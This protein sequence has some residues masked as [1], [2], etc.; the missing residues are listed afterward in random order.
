MV[1]FAYQQLVKLL[2]EKYENTKFPIIDAIAQDDNKEDEEYEQ[3]SQKYKGAKRSWCVFPDN[4]D[5]KSLH[6]TRGLV[7]LGN[8]CFFNSVL[9][10]FA[11]THQLVSHY[12]P[13]DEIFNS[14]A[15]EKKYALWTGPLSL[16][17]KLFY[18]EMYSTYNQN[19]L[20]QQNSKLLRFNLET[21]TP[22]KLFK[23]IIKIVPHFRGFGQQDSQELLRFLQNFVRE[24][25]TLKLEKSGIKVDSNSSTSN[26]IIDHVFN[27]RMTSTV[28]CEHC[29]N[30]SQIYASELDVSVPIP[31]VNEIESD[32]LE[33]M[34]NREHALHSKYSQLL[35]PELIYSK[36]LEYQKQLQKK[37]SVSLHH[38]LWKHMSSDFLDKSGD[39]GYLC[40]ECSHKVEEAK[41]A[42]EEEIT[43]D[44]SVDKSE[45]ISDDDDESGTNENTS[46]STKEEEKKPEKPKKE[47]RNGVKQFAFYQLP[48]V[49]TIHL[50][51]FVESSARKHKNK[52]IQYLSHL[53]GSN[54]FEKDDTDVEFPEYLTL[55]GFIHSSSQEVANQQYRLYG[56]VEHSGSLNFGHYVAFTRGCKIAMDGSVQR[57]DDWC[58]ISDQNV[59]GSLSFEQVQK[60]AQP[61]V[62][63][64]EKV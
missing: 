29:G 13:M 50:K 8:T 16:A 55:D 11:Q 60:A 14:T 49:L 1:T 28:I 51:R 33:K 7:N 64:Y 58:Y 62:L 15:F 46:N 40:D 37:N 34:F 36:S 59:R 9:Q 3:Q 52:R 35:D 54:G 19:N 43:S 41:T 31:R 4:G 5:E 45:I 42:N 21:I 38:C 53:L 2:P 22:Q 32:S 24:E 25:Y 12:L 26:N 44:E 57:S 6:A 30:V 17:L 47:F 61:Y 63:F 48:N 27:T 18:E 10:C 39:N 56:I 23:Q 20:L